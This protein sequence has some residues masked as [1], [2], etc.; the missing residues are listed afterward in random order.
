MRRAMVGLGAL[1][2]ELATAH[3]AEKGGKPTAVITKACW[4]AITTPKC[5]APMTARQISS[6]RRA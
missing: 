1:R 2:R 4:L 3:F 5:V 6:C